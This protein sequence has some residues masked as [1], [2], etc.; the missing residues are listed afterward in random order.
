AAIGAGGNGGGEVSP[1][2]LLE[3]PGGGGRRVHAELHRLESGSGEDHLVLLSDA[4]AMDALEADARLLR[5]LEGL[6]RV[7]RTMAHEIKAPLSAMMINLDLLRESLVRAPQPD[8]ETAPQQYVQVLR[9]E[10][11]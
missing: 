5:Q 6:A 9:D 11:H 2:L 8:R 10:L 4:R 3:V 7:Y 1:S